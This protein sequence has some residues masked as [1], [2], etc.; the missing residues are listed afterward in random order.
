MCTHYLASTVISS[1]P[2]LLIKYFKTT[3]RHLIS[4]INAQFVPLQD[5]FF[6]SINTSNKINSHSNTQHVQICKW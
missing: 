3:P 2:F 6:K 1:V 5:E 4:P